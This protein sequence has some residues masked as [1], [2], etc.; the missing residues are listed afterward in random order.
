MVILIFLAVSC[1]IIGLCSLYISSHAS[2]CESVTVPTTYTAAAA[3]SNPVEVRCFCE[4]NLIASFSDNNIKTVCSTYLT[5]IQISQGIQY[6]VIIT[7]SLT[8]F[9]FGLIVDKLINFVRPASKSAGLLTKTTVYTIFIIFNSVFIPLLIY[10]N[11][12]GF[13]PSNYVSFITIISTDVKNF[14]AISNLSFY[15]SFNTVWYKN[16]SVIYV[17]FM[18]VNTIVI[19]VFFLLDKCTASK[20]SL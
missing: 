15:P 8:N 14:F 2:N 1:A 7:S 17:N 16:V 19:W 18:I 10:A 4:A 3:S 13:Q 12:F 6:A 5:D 20:G 11:I 9:L